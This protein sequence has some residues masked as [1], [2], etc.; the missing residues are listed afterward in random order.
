MADELQSLLDRIQSE[1]LRKAEGERERIL[2]EAKTA[3]QKT[4]DQARDEAARLVADAQREADALTGKGRE[5]LRQAARDTLLSLR[6][7]LQE[8]L[9]RIVSV[10][11]NDHF[12]GEM[13]ASILEIICKAYV[14]HGSTIERLDVLVHEKERWTLEKVFLTRLSADL[15]TRVNIAPRPDINNGFKLIFNGGDLVYDFTDEA[16]TETL[17]TF[18]SPKLAELLKN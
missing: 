2:A 5:A 18:L 12:Q 10:A 17:C 15:R 9:R 13:L 8:R 3:A 16:L 7:Q 11:V 6:T 1:G 4:L 14:S